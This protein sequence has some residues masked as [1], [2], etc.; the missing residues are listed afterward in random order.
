MPRSDDTLRALAH[1]D[2]AGWHGLPDDADAD[3]VRGA[4]G[5]GVN[6]RGGGMLSWHGGAAGPEGVLIWLNDSRVELVEMPHP[7]LPL[8]ATELLGDP[9]YVARTPW[10][11]SGTQEVWPARG[12]AVHANFDGVV[13]VMAFTPM[14]TEAFEQHRFATAGRPPRR[15]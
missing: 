2:L 4:L 7:R 6:D 15:P 10:S 12:L 11:R 5:D 9:D 3:W 1:G 13:R 14:T 8:E